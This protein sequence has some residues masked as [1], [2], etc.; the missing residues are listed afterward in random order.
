MRGRP[1]TFSSDRSPAAEPGP[2]AEPLGQPASVPTPQDPNHPQLTT[3]LPPCQLTP[4]TGL[5]SLRACP[6][7]RWWLC[8]CR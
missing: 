5:S 1:A 2:S 7:D 3:G 4:G 8:P 6:G